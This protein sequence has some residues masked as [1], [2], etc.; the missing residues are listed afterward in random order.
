MMNYDER[1]V[2]DLMSQ[3]LWTMWW[4][5]WLVIWTTIWHTWSRSHLNLSSSLLIDRGLSQH[6]II[7]NHMCTCY[8]TLTMI[9]WSIIASITSYMIDT[10]HE[11]VL[12]TTNEDVSS[13]DVFNDR[14]IDWCFD[15]QQS[16]TCQPSMSNINFIVFDQLTY[17][18]SVVYPIAHPLN[19]QIVHAIAGWLLLAS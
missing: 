15:M 3:R 10:T 8:C 5:D 16:I 17:H 18:L 6:S 7:D 4:Y 2:N 1:H 12:S 9:L 19:V 11:H 13:I 14:S